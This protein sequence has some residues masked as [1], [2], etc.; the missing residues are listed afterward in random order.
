MEQRSEIRKAALERDMEEFERMFPLNPD[1]TRPEGAC[2]PS[3]RAEL[4]SYETTEFICIACMKG[5]SCIGCGEV[6]LKPDP[7]LKSRDSKNADEDVTMEE[8]QPR[9]E[10]GIPK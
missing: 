10:L 1:G 4:S 5:G 8:T 9:Q 6:A 7:R 3:R 2:R